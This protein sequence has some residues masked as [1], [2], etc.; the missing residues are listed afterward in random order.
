L[1]QP[2]EAALS[3]WATRIAP[4]VSLPPALPVLPDESADCNVLA[5]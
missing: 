5:D 3:N 4:A 2:T 1:Q